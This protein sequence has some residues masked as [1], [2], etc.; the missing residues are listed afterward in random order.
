MRYALGQVV[1]QDLDVIKVWSNMKQ[2]MVDKLEPYKDAAGQVVVINGKIFPQ[3]TF[4]QANALKTAWDK[5]SD[6]L[7]AQIEKEGKPTTRIT[8]VKLAFQGDYVKWVQD[9]FFVFDDGRQGFQKYEGKYLF[10]AA[11]RDLLAVFDLFT[12]NLSTQAWSARNIETALERMYDA[13][14][15]TT[16]GFL[17]KWP[18]KAAEAVSKGLPKPSDLFGFVGNMADIIKY[19]V[20]GGGLFML[21]W[22]VLRD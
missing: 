7:R 20:I 14:D 5:F 1:A 11:T 19:G 17:L 13:L 18:L 6:S 2:L 10:P 8:Q 22:Y 15:E 3:M 16:G 12:I 4:N 21:Y 9:L